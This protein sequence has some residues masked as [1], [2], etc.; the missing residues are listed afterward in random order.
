MAG[1]KPKPTALVA[2]KVVVQVQFA[3]PV[4]MAI[5]LNPNQLPGKVD[6]VCNV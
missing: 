2:T 5:P 1:F 3:K 6:R 4:V